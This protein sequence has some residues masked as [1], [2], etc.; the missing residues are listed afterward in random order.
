MKEYAEELG[1]ETIVDKKGE[2]DGTGTRY[3]EVKIAPKGKIS[4]EEL[5]ELKNKLN[6]F[7]VSMG[8]DVLYKNRT[9]EQ[10]DIKKLNGANIIISKD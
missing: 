6:G 1:W 7:V 4:P 2:V 8:R 3:F 10:E 5:R 9:L